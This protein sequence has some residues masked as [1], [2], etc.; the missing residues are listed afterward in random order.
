M[1]EVILDTNIFVRFLIRDIEVQFKRS[2]AIFEEIER[3]ELEGQLSILVTDEL[4]W[5]LENYYEIDRKI[6][7]PEILQL[8]A[9]KNIKTIEVSKDLFIKILERM[10]TTKFDFTD[11]YLHQIAKD[12][13]IISFD[14]DF[15]KLK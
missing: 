3:D 9:L 8:L 15:E 2:Q 4:I 7:I 13:K 5:V 10:Q 12:R 1:E 14:K 11:L 6:F